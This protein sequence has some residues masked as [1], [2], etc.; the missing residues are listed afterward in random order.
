MQGAGYLVPNN[1]EE[2]LSGTRQVSSPPNNQTKL[3][4]TILPYYAQ[5]NQKP[6]SLT[7][8]THTVHELCVKTDKCTNAWR[9]RNENLVS[10]ELTPR[11]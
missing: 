3:N 10:S 2:H 9:K 4:T 8:M 1:Q 7:H 11:S 5:D 6:A